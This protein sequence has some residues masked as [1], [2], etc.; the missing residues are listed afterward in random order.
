M[1]KIYNLALLVLF[2]FAANAQVNVTYSV[3][4]TEYIAAGGTIA[5][6]GIRIGGD[7]GSQGASNNGNTMSD[8]NPTDANSA[9]TDM[10]NN[11]WSITVTYA[12]PGATQSYKFVNGDWGMN[13]GT[14]EGSTIASDGCGVDERKSYGDFVLFDWTSSSSV[15]QRN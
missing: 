7:F 6:N 3:D 8:W 5:N 13:E 2:A 14:D 10:G 15:W 4:V 12:A 1:K 9:L 11:V